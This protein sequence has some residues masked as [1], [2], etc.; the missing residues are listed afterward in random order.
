MVYTCIGAFCGRFA[1]SVHFA[2]H[3][4]RMILISQRIE[5]LERILHDAKNAYCTML[6]LCT[7]RVLC[8]SYEA[9]SMC[10]SQGPCKKVWYVAKICPNFEV[11]CLRGRVESINRDRDRV[12]DRDCVLCVLCRSAFYAWGIYFPQVFL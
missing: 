12:R 7:L 5:R 2:I 9:K 10:R 1:D 8:V 3:N 11:V 4:G 6:T